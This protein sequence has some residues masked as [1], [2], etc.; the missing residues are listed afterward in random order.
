MTSLKILAIAGSLRR[1][2]YNRALVR[3]AAELAPAGATVE[4]AEIGGL[5]LYDEDVNAAGP[6]P[7]VAELKRRIAEADALFIATPEYN[8]GVPGAL[9]NFIDWTSRRPNQPW[10]GKPVAIAGA[11]DG[12]FGTVRAQLALRP[13]LAAVDAR[14]VE[15]PEVHVSRV[16]DKVDAEGRLTDE[17]TREKLRQLLEVLVSRVP[18]R[19]PA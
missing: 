7:A 5:P 8:H 6:P 4:I 17:P 9:K 12:G 16:Q 14:V 18:E 3:A 1:G 13:I 10:K 11:S 2:S 19:H 15:N